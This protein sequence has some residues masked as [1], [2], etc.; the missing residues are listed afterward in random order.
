[1]ALPYLR[2]HFPGRPVVAEFALGRDAEPTPEEMFD[3]AAKAVASGYRISRP[4]LEEATG[5]ALEGAPTPGEGAFPPFAGGA[6]AGYADFGVAKPLQNARSAPHDKIPVRNARTPL[7]GDLG[8]DAAGRALAAD[9]QPLADR[10]RAIL[11]Q[12][13]ETWADAFA[14]LAE[15]MPE[16]LQDSDALAEL[17]EEE[18]ARAIANSSAQH[19]PKCGQFLSGDGTC[20]ACKASENADAASQPQETKCGWTREQMA[21]YKQAISEQYDS[22]ND[23]HYNKTLKLGRVGGKLVED[24]LAL[25]HTENIAGFRIELETSQT[26]HMRNKHGEGNE[27]WPGQIGLTKEDFLRIPEIL[28]DY[29]FLEFAEPKRTKALH[30]YKRYPDGTMNMVPAIF[31]MKGVLSIRTLWKKELPKK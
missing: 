24:V 26:R 27:K 29:D 2:E 30:F 14:A 22:L 9:M 6:S 15:E 19:C 7:R 8:H 12:P 5:Y 25:D 17:M 4:E 31:R 11:A 10:L 23:S 3:L 21:E 18:M 28:A 16:L 1:M 13:E 20:S